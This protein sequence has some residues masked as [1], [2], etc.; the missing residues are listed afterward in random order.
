MILP[1][2]PFRCALLSLD[3][4]L[5]LQPLSLG[6][7]TTLILLKSD[8]DEIRKYRRGLKFGSQFSFCADDITILL[9][10]RIAY[11]FALS[12]GKRD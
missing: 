11:Q 3:L 7:C 9:C 5:L 8:L 10:I 12:F 2:Q 6:A 4:T 1:G